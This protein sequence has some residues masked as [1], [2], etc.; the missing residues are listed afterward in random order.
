MTAVLDTEAGVVTYADQSV[1][2]DGS[3]QDAKDEYNGYVAAVEAHRKTVGIAAPMASPL[4]LLL[5]STDGTI[6]L[7]PDP[8]PPTLD[9]V[10]AAKRN[11]LEIVLAQKLTKGF[12]T[13]MM[14]P[15]RVYP[16][17]QTDQHN[18]NTLVVRITTQDADQHGD[19]KFMCGENGVWARRSHTAQQ[20]KDL[21]VAVQ[22]YV[23]SLL[24]DYEAKRLELTQAGDKDAVDRITWS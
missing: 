22:D 1:R 24:D 9:Q 6:E 2:F 8:P 3:L 11:E 21:A 4:V 5:M 14:G 15:S 23:V 17:N 7:K 10:K 12:A 13:D 19:L 20:I 16:I 18:L